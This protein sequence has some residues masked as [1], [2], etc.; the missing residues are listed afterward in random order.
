[1]PFSAPSLL[2]FALF[3][4]GS[5]HGA[6]VGFGLCNLLHSPQCWDYRAGHHTHLGCGIE[7]G[8]AVHVASVTLASALP[9]MGLS[10]QPDW[11]HQ[12]RQALSLC[13]F[14]CRHCVSLP[15]ICTKLENSFWL[16]CWQHCHKRSGGSGESLPESFWCLQAPLM[17][18]ELGMVMTHTCNPCT[19]GKQ[20]QEDCPGFEA[21]RRLHI[22][23][24]ASLDFQMRP[25]EQFLTL[26]MVCLF[27]FAAGLDRVQL[28]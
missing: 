5:C 15:V 13:L 10:C 14:R 4:T 8:I 22:E 3:E 27:F 6:Q 16:E 21:S 20:R 23:L 2:L 24:Q 19:L 17:V 7:Q 11:V 9:H 25:P 12:P 18:F 26:K 1:M 28:D